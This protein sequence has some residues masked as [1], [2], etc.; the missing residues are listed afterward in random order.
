MTRLI[1]FVF[2]VEGIPLARGY[3]KWRSHFSIFVSVEDT[4]C[5]RYI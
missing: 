2:G 1:V 3:Y 5:I 4:K